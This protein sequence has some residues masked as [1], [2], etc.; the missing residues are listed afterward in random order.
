DPTTSKGVHGSNGSVNITWTKAVAGVLSC[1]FY[2]TLDGAL[3]RAPSCVLPPPPVISTPVI[4]ERDQCIVD[5]SSLYTLTSRSSVSFAMLRHGI[6]WDNDGD[7]DEWTPFALQ[8]TTQTI[9]HTWPTPGA[10]TFRVIAEDA[11]GNRSA[12]RS[13]TA[14]CTGSSCTPVPRHC[15]GSGGWT[16]SSCN[17]FNACPVG[18]ICQDPG[19]VCVSASCPDG[20]HR[21][22]LNQCV[23]ADEALPIAGSCSV[24]FRSFTVNPTLVRRGDTT[25]VSWSVVRARS[26]NVFGTSQ[27]TLSGLSGT[28]V[29]SAPI[30]AQTI[31]TLSCLDLNG[32][33]S[34]SQKKTVNIAPAFEEG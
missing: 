11:S 19:G 22:A 25:R 14:V 8:N 27:P 9:S 15:I 16:N 3:C 30:L 33:P 4:I 32:F 23:C 24:V 13:F 31:F 26:C 28:D 1:P 29:V 7:W 21:N 17:T 2:Y 12:P 5:S 6:D 34:A 18:T 10:H 20:Q